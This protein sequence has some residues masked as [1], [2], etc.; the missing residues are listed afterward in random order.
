[1]GQIASI[2]CLLNY[3]IHKWLCSFNFIHM[4][5]FV[6]CLVGC[7]ATISP[8]PPPQS[9]MH[10]LSKVINEIH[11]MIT[12]VVMVTMYMHNMFTAI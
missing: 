5:N 2:S 3:Y 10:Q 1:M 11:E 4:I 12:L 6:D 7:M 9:L 8:P